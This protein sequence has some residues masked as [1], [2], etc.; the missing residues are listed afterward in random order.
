[1]VPQQHTHQFRL[2]DFG[3]QCQRCVARAIG[4]VHGRT[5]IQQKL[6]HPRKIPL[7]D[8]HH[9]GGFAILAREIR[10]GALVEQSFEFG[11]ALVMTCA[12]QRLIACT[13]QGGRDVLGPRA[14]GQ[15]LDSV[16]IASLRRHVRRR[17]PATIPGSDFRVHG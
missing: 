15:Q 1:M 9:E 10:I 7:A 17:T 13:P 5:A 8:C 4:G 2:V 14:H 16:G 12:Q 11:L 6:A 3:G